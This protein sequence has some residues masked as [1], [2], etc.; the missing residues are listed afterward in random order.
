MATGIILL[1]YLVLWLQYTPASVTGVDGVQFRYFLP[2]SGIFA[3]CACECVAG[4]RRRVGHA[5][6]TSHTTP[7]S[8]SAVSESTAVPSV[9]DAARA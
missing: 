4:L 3:L 9:A 1:T 5:S 7:R 8:S 6:H 2:L